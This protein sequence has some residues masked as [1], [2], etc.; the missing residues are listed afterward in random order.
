MSYDTAGAP[1]VV[2]EK[3][4]EIG[5][6]HTSDEAT[7]FVRNEPAAFLLLRLPGHHVVTEVHELLV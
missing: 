7:S 5:E 2:L 4:S 6:E 1:R 3:L